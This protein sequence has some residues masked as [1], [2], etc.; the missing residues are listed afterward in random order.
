MEKYLSKNATRLEYIFQ[1][2]IRG[3]HLVNP[4]PVNETAWENINTMILT[5]LGIPVYE[6]SSGSH[7]SGMDID[8]LWGTLINKSAKYSKQKKNFKISSYR[9]TTACGLDNCGSQDEI[10]KEINKRKN[11]EFYSII[12]RDESE[13]GLMKYEWLLI[14]SDYIGLD[15]SSYTWKPMIGKTGKHKDKQ[16]GWE[17]NNVNGCYMSIHFSMSS[18]LW[19]HVEMTE[20][21]KKF[22]IARAVAES[23]PKINYIELVDKLNVI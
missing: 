5:T 22:I 17:T 19:I 20:E 1:K 10:I 3:Y 23:K 12:V 21:I 6:E 2:C 15:P 9:L 7:A 8:C 4:S 14:P 16:I 13:D 18:Q 11:F